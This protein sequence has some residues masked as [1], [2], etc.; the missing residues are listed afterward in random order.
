MKRLFILLLLVLM[1]L[2]LVWAATGACCAQDQEPTATQVCHLWQQQCDE[3]DGG[4]LDADGC[5]CCHHFSGSPLSAT[6]P[7]AA[8]PARLPE[9]RFDAT[10]Y[11]SHIPDLVPPPDR[12]TRA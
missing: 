10:H 1:P 11:V 2:Q 5:D 6:Q 7:S 9:L 8:T 12:Q 4:Q 3:D